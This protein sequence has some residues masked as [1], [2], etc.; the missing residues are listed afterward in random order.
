[1]LNKTKARIRFQICD[2]KPVLLAVVADR[3]CSALVICVQLARLRSPCSLLIP[4]IWVMACL[5]YKSV[6][7][8]DLADSGGGPRRVCIG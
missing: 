8:C 6:K 7:H 1:M 3:M 2:G 5:S 4:D